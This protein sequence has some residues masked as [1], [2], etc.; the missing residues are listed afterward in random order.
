MSHKKNLYAIAS[1]AIA[2]GVTVGVG[3]KDANAAPKKGQK[4][5][6]C[7]GTNSCKGKNGCSVEQSQI[8]AVAKVFPGKFSK[9]M[10]V[11]CAGNS[12]CAA[13]SG[14]LGWTEKKTTNECF[15]AGGFVFAKGADG[16]LTIKDKNGEKKV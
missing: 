7:F 12:D 15:D 14:F 8:D 9:S 6:E 2:A 1:A 13:K 11:D 10:P 3:P 16:K 4:S 5:V